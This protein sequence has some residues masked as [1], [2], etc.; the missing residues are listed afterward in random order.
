MFI[1]KV[2]VSDVIDTNAYFYIDEKTKH[3]WLI[4]AGAEAEKLLGLVKEQ[5]WV[6]EGILLT[7]GHFDHIGAVEKIS[8]DLGVRYKIHS[9]GTALLENP[10][11]NLSR[12]FDRNIVL[13]NAECFNDNDIITLNADSENK[14]KV[15]HVPGHTP[16]SVIFYDQKNELAFV[17]DTIFKNSVGN[18][19]FLGG[20]AEMLK[21]SINEKVFALPDN[22]VLYSGHTPETS[23]GVEKKNFWR[24]F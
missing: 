20:D 4:D 13:K 15:I 21:K 19:N 11:F 12:R 3:G 5:K 2:I 24:F 14:L 22:T 18:T 7:H 23:V 16:D 6:I 1:K 9:E 17:G 10:Y 8:K